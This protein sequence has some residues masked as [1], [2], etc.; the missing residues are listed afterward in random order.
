L[1]TPI[2]RLTRTAE[3]VSTGDL[4]AQAPEGQ[5]E[6][7]VLAAAFNTMTTE[8]RRTLEGLEQR[9]AERTSQLGRASEQM[10]HRANQ[11]QTVTEV[12]KLVATIQ[13][14]EKLLALITQ[15]ISDRFGYYHTGIFLLDDPGE[16]AIL[17]AANSE[18]GQRML[19]R[20]HK[21]K[22]GQEGIVGFV[23][24]QGEAR[25][26]LDVGADAV[27]FD[28]P[29]LPNTR[30]E[31]AL[32]LKIGEKVIGALDVQSEKP[33]AFNEDDVLVLSTLA[34]QVA[35]AIENTRLFSETRKTLTELQTLHGQYLQHQWSQAVIAA[36]K[37][38]Y[39]YSN[40]RLEPVPA[41]SASQ[42]WESAARGEPA[43]ITNPSDSQEGQSSPSNLI[44]PIT[45]RGQVIGLYN[46]GEPEQPG[47][48]EKEDIEFVKAIAD[49]VGLA[50][51]NARLLEQTQT[52]A[53]REHLV[54]E[55]TSKMRASNDPQV[56]LETAKRELR[57]ALRAKKAEIL[58]PANH[59]KADPAEEPPVDPS[60]NGHNAGEVGTAET[61]TRG[62]E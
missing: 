51:E 4:W 39:Q 16:H 52:R 61:G 5:D 47:G 38:G 12:A 10:K 23:T 36:G 22:V 24:S 57:Q 30:S 14:Q 34:D 21:L 42:L 3:K 49:Q 48:W 50:L 25:V 53:E 13:D 43:V 46:L 56:I 44:V 41:S 18:G 28:N 8:L 62:E 32:P 58:L 31:L 19:V 20:N 15:L 29:D 37:S 26:A 55:I 2:E 60:G 54:A 9:I 11:L 40:G 1:T 7:G 33:A 35:I 59:Q 45:V 6:I 17:R 27:F